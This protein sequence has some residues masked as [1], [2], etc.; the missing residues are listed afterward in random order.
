MKDK[1]KFIGMNKSSIVSQLKS[2][3][4]S[5]VHPKPDYD[6]HALVEEN[7]IAW[8][9]RNIA[10]LGN[11]HFTYQ[12]YPKPELNN[13][14]FKMQNPSSKSTAIALLSDWASDTAESHLIARQAADNDYSIHLGDTYYV[15]NKKEIADNFNTDYGGTWPYGKQGSFALLGNHEMYSSGR[16]YFQQL[17][18]YMG[19]FVKEHDKPQQASFFCLEN[20]FWRIIGLDTGYYSLKGILGIGPNLKLDLPDEHK[21]WLEKTVRLNDDNRGIIFLSHHQSFSAFEDEFPNPGKYISSIMKPGRDILWLWGHEHWFSVYGANKLENGSNVYARCVG[22]SGMPVEL[23]AKKKPKAPKN[24]DASHAFN[25]NLTL[26]DGR[27][28]E[29]MD[30]EIPI[31]YNGF[32]MLNVQDNKLRIDYYD[33][34]DKKED[35]RKIL[36]EEWEVDIATGKLSGIDIVDFTEGSTKKLTVFSKGIRNAIDG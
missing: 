33:D 20:E 30:D 29:K 35:R 13:G 34:N 12:S 11:S 18:P 23:N 9:I 27:L 17:L 10:N 4:D 6:M 22:N 14:I 19:N 28:R 36:Q 7:K 1:R 15:G 21:E 3:W 25:R 24:T 31:G 8:I 5:I 16:S 2:V 32:C 26:F